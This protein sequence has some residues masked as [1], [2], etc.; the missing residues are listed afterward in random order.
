MYLV[1][2]NDI[3]STSIKTFVDLDWAQKHYDTN[4]P[5]VEN[6]YRGL[7]RIVD[8]TFEIDIS[9]EVNVMGCNLIDEEYHD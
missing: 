6:S 1:I 2:V 8:S 5:E 9:L 4:P 3:S 7:Y